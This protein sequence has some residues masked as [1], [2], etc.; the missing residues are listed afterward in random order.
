MRTNTSSLTVVIRGALEAVTVT[1]LTD[2][3]ATRADGVAYGEILSADTP[4]IGKGYA[5]R[6][7]EAHGIRRYGPVMSAARLESAITLGGVKP[8]FIG[9]LGEALEHEFYGANAPTL[10]AILEQHGECEIADV[11]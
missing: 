7:A 6:L 1:F 9:T 4:V 11:A 2:G 8:G 5:G 3:T 10:E